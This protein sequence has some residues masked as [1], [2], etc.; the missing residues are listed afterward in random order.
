M[1]PSGNENR[2]TGCRVSKTIPILWFVVV[3]THIYILNIYIILSQQ[4]YNIRQ[5]QGL[6]SY[7]IT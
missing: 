3:H 2:D 1:S 6:T 4:I 7:T 5:V